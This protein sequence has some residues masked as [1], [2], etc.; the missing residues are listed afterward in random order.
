MCLFSPRLYRR[1]DACPEAPPDELL[2]RVARGMVP[3]GD[4]SGLEFRKRL[5]QLSTIGASRSSNAIALPDGGREARRARV[6]DTSS[7]LSSTGDHDARR[8]AFRLP[9]LGEVVSADL[10]LALL[11][12]AGV[13][14]RRDARGGSSEATTS[15]SRGETDERRDGVRCSELSISSSVTDLRRTDWRPYGRPC[16]LDASST[17]GETDERR[18]SSSALSIWPSV[19][20]GLRADWRVD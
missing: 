17:R 4:R 18:L 5:I 6:A 19:T 10:E 11:P 2:R 9:L 20:D 12:A 13:D 16:C 8:A 7:R 3:R 14:M 15:S 1:H